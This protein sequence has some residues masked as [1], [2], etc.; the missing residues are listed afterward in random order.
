MTLKKTVLMVVFQHYS[1]NGKNDHEVILS[2][3][4]PP[5]RGDTQSQDIT[6]HFSEAQSV[7]SAN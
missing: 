1:L 6:L 7:S 3:A 2:G 4:P 5:P